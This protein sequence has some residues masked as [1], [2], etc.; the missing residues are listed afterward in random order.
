MEEKLKMMMG[1]K[2]NGILKDQEDHVDEFCD[3]FIYANDIN[4]QLTLVNCLFASSK[5]ILARYALCTS[6]APFGDK[7]ECKAPCKAVRHG[8]IHRPCWFSLPCSSHMVRH[9]RS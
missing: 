5:K 8:T 2:E 9:R 6:N 7:L 4:F 1:D 3:M